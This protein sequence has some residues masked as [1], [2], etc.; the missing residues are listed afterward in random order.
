[1]SKLYRHRAWMDIFEELH[2]E[3]CEDKSHFIHR[4]QFDMEHIH[5]DRF[6]RATP[7][8][9]TYFVQEAAGEHCQLLQV[10]DYFLKDKNLFWALS[11]TKVEVKRLPHLGERVIV[12]TW[13]MPTTR[14]AYPRAFA[15]YDSHGGLLF[16][17]VSLW[18]LMDRTARTMVLPGKSGVSVEGTCFGDEPQ[19][20]RAIAVQPMEQ[21]TLR[22]VGYSLLDQNGH[23]NNTRY[24]DW[25]MDLPDSD[26]HREHTVQEFTICYMNEAREGDE[27]ALNYALSDGKILTVDA[28]RKGERIFSAQ[29]IFDDVL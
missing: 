27:I 9:L 16:E 28:Q 1:M 2:P 29:L 24:F 10:D 11:R 19:I 5:T 14:V 4:M 15:A 26:F 13:P 20:P 12:E 23:M 8:A 7:A 17:G 3:R 21:E 25:L 22:K 6:G 18:V